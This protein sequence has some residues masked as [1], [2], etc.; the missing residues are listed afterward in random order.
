M[1]LVLKHYKATAVVL[2]EHLQCAIT[3]VCKCAEYYVY[4]VYL[5]AY[6]LACDALLEHTRSQA[7]ANSGR[8]DMI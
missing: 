7:T 1:L 8:H 3:A 4:L 2:A 5:R 6:L